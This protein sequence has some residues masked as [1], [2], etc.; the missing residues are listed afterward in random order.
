MPPIQI[1]I[2]TK[3]NTSNKFLEYL[4]SGLV[5]G[6]NNQVTDFIEEQAKEMASGS[7]IYNV[8]ESP[9]MK[10]RIQNETTLSS[11]IK[12]EKVSKTKGKSQSKVICDSE[13]AS[14]VEWGTGLHGELEAP[15]RIYPKE[16]KVMT[17][18][19]KNGERVFASST[20]GQYPKPF[21]RGAIFKLKAKL[22]AVLGYSDKVTDVPPTESQMFSKSGLGKL[23]MG[24]HSQINAKPQSS[25]KMWDQSLRSQM[26]NKK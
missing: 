3:L 18:I 26:R 14:W 9:E 7:E 8:P 19:G 20:A 16:K 5:D 12:S 13:H 6:I 4:L 24:L 11:K 25:T 15:H 1:N 23:N 17:W 10:D 2:S 22:K 21:M